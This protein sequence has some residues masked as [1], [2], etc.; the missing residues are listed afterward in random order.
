M[1]GIR[2]IDRV[3]LMPAYPRSHVVHRWQVGVYHCWNRCVRRASL[4]GIDPLTGKDYNYRRD[5]IRKQEQQL[6]SLFA[7]EIAF[8]SELRNHFH[9]TLRTRPDLAAAWSN[10]EVVKRWLQ[11]AQLKRGCC[12]EPKEPTPARIRSELAIRGRVKKLRRRL[13]CVSWFM[14]ALCENIARRSNREDGCTGKF[15]E[16]RFSCRKLISERDILICGIYVDLNPIR[17]GEASLPERAVHS[18]AFDRILGRKRR[19]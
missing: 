11:I 7:I 12:D 9:L 19:R 13:S 4:C 2:N 3:F 10:E 17:A 8:H 1:P 14:G 5:W 16:S 18:S 15:W 6:A